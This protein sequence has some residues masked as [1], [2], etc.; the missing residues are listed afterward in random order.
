V[1][2]RFRR[3]ATA[4]TREAEDSGSTTEAQRDEGVARVSSPHSFDT[5]H[6]R[7][8]AVIAARGF[9][10]MAD[11]DHARG[12]QSVGATLN[13]TRLLIFGNPRGGTAVMACAQGAG[14]DLPLKAL[15]TQDAG[16]AVTVSWNE[17]AWIASRHKLGDCAKPAI[18][19]MDGA[20]KG[21]VAEAVKQ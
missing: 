4:F 20:L 14:L 8:V 12:A 18:D 5:T 1:W 2:S 9:V 17:P 7:L 16:G 21:L 3:N 10:L 6:A 19:A 11:V 15:I 13:P